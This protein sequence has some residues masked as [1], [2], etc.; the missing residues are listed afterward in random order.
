M[1]W[2]IVG[3]GEPKP[4]IRYGPPA[5]SK[6]HAERFRKEHS[7]K[8]GRKLFEKKGRLYA[9]IER[10]YTQPQ[11]LICAMVAEDAYL[12]DKALHYTVKSFEQQK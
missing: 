5:N 6:E 1:L 8:S 12:K 2:Y 9:R 3:K 10:T 4:E 7:G 11:Q